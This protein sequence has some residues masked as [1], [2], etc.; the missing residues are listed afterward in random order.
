MHDDERDELGLVGAAKDDAATGAAPTAHPAAVVQFM[1]LGDRRR[2]C[3]PVECE[4]DLIS[5][6]GWRLA[7]PAMLSRRCSRRR[8]WWV[9]RSWG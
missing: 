1:K 9:G 6:A 3:E 7:Q 2:S 4:A 8:C 5:V